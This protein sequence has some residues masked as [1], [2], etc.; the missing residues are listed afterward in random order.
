M[1]TIK[2]IIEDNQD[3]FNQMVVEFVT[4]KTEVK[5]KANKT[6]CYFTALGNEYNNTKFI[7]NYQKFLMDISKLPIDETVFTKAMGSHIQKDP[8][9]FPPSFRENY[10]KLNNDLYV[11]PHSS[12]ENKMKHITNIC[13]ELNIKVDFN[14]IS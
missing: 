4:R 1:K 10:F 3:E 8:N 13:E 11:S 6:V 7:N 14:I 9:N 2:Q 12:T 5:R